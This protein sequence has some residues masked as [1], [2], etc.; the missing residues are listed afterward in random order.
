MSDLIN[1]LRKLNKDIPLKSLVD[2]Y[3]AFLLLILE[4]KK[5][6]D[7]DEMLRYCE[8]SLSLIEPL[9]VYNK[10]YIIWN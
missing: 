8:L 2:E 3:Y 7:F 5:K 1:R 10:F 4:F 9:I 6:K